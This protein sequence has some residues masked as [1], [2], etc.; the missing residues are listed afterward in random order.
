MAEQGSPQTPL[1][2]QKKAFVYH[3]TL[4]DLK[5]LRL[6]R[7]DLKIWQLHGFLAVQHC[8]KEAMEKRESLRFLIS[9]KIEKMEQSWSYYVILRYPRRNIRNTDNVLSSYI[10][11]IR[12]R[13]SQKS[14]KFSTFHPFFFAFLSLLLFRQISN[15][16]H[17][18]RIYSGTLT[19][20]K[21]KLPKL[22]FYAPLFGNS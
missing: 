11:F 10:T 8:K 3:T 1:Q 17:V 20:P 5:K 12:V 14:R 7:Y 22:L 21:S 18:V 15:F 9:C 13:M 6:R 2:A 16:S 4:L 19:I